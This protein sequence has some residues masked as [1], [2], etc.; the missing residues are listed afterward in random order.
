MNDCK[1]LDDYQRIHVALSYMSGPNVDEW[2]SN[3]YDYKH[4]EATATTAAGWS[5]SIIQFW[6]DLEERFTDSNQKRQAQI[7]LEILTQGTGSAE[8][9]FEKLNTLV[10]QAG[11]QFDDQYI[12]KTIE[13]NVNDSIID[14]VYASG[15]IPDTYDT[16]KAKVV[17][18]DS[19]WRRRNEHKKHRVR[20]TP[21]S[22]PAP[23]SPPQRTYQQPYQPPARQLYTGGDR[24]DGTGVTFGGAGKA[25]EIDE[26]KKKGLCFGCGQPGHLNRDCPKKDRKFQVRRLELSEAEK[27]ELIKEWSTPTPSGFPTPQQ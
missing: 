17:N 13:M 5:M 16:W 15:T 24:Q 20:H 26:A 11:Y 2:V 23:S 22:S 27:A 4:A 19:L 3:Y 6:K 25:M 1:E 21:A 10:V 18:L 9:Y 7:Q 8:D 12:L 14:R